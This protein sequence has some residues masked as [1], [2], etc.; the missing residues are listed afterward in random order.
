[1]ASFAADLLQSCLVAPVLLMFQARSVVQVLL[2]RD[3]GWPAQTRGDGILSLSKGWRAAWWITAWGAA[4]LGA[5]G[6]WQPVLLP[7]LVPL[8]G[9]MMAAPWIIAWTSR[10]PRSRLFT[11]PEEV[12]APAVL[13]RAGDQRLRWTRPELARPGPALT[14]QIHHA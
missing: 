5:A 9:P 4:L 2:G 8:G 6:L 7:W 12:A 13:R 11:T 1:M 10:P 14:R 3:G